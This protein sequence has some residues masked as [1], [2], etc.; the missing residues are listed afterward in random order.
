M[1]DSIDTQRSFS[2]RA[3]DSPL[4]NPLIELRNLTK[5]FGAVAAA[6]AID[7]EVTAGEVFGFI[8]PNGAGKTTTIKMMCGLLAPDSGTVRIA[9]IDMARQPERAKQQIGLVPDRPYLYE[10]LTATEFLRFTADLYAVEPSRFD[11][12]SQELLQL[13]TLADRAHELIESF[14]HGMKQRLIMAAALLH[15]PP[16]LV[17]D[18][19]MVG[20]DPK[21][22]RM[23]RELFRKLAAEGTSVFMSTHT[24]KLAEDVCDRIAVIDRGTIRATGTM[25]ELRRTAR[26]GDADLEQVFFELT[27]AE[28]PVIAVDLEA[29]MNKR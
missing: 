23:V 4:P 7:L 13:F 10:K 17:V 22:I 5:H 2:R 3:A 12:R 20:L 29:G 25:E 19:P 9:G 8:G 15:Q 26:M 14:S 18:E 28:G 24:L 6:E 16:L 27:T 11:N 21:G 1:R